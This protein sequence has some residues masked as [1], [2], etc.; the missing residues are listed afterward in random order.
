MALIVYLFSD[1]AVYANI[2]PSAVEALLGPGRLAVGPLETYHVV[3]IIYG[4]LACPM[5]FLDFSKT[6]PL[7]Y[8]TMSL[9]YATF[10]TMLFLSLQFII[11]G[12][13]ASLLALPAVSVGSLP[14]L[15]GAIAYSLV[16]H[17][18][19]PVRAFLAQPCGAAADASVLSIGPPPWRHIQGIVAPIQDEKKRATATV[20]GGSYLAIV[21]LY[22]AMAMSGL[23]AFGGSHYAECTPGSLHTCVPQPIFTSNFQTYHVRWIG[24]ALSLY[25]LALSTNYPLMAITLRNNAM[26][27]TG[28]GASWAPQYQRFRWPAVSALTSIP[29]FVIAFFVRDLGLLVTITGSYFACAIMFILPPALVLGARG[30][31]RRVLALK[32][33]DGARNPLYAPDK[34]LGGGKALPWAVLVMSVFAVL[35]TTIQLVKDARSDA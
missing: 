21:V 27:A 17:H 28:F 8:V 14:L 13:G 24:A 22:L 31:E 35:L 18:S 15:F 32:L 33:P 29:P 1:L 2:I 6:K 4:L 19:V 34:S 12:R 30:Y 11:Q 20:Y 10:A 26:Q 7:Q 25:P 23:V 9:R 5:C 16:N 3:L